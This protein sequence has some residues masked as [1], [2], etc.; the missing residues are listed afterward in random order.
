MDTPVRAAPRLDHEVEAGADLRPH[1]IVRAREGREPR[2]DSPERPAGPSFQADPR[3]RA[4]KIC[5]LPMSSR[6]H[7]PGYCV[8]PDVQ[9][10]WTSPS[11]M[12]LVDESLKVLDAVTLQPF[13]VTGVPVG[14]AG[15]HS[16]A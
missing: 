12:L 10:V 15:T 3:E 8:T 5:V 1:V 11:Y 7:M 2:E 4:K 16:L 14:A 13:S 6:T 9:R